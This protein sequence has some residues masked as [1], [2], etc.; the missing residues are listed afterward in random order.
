MRQT[1]RDAPP[2]QEPSD[3]ARHG[4]GE[5]GDQHHHPEEGEERADGD[6]LDPLGELRGIDLETERERAD[7]RKRDE[8]ADEGASAQRRRPD[9]RQ[10]VDCRDRRGARRTQRGNERRAD[11]DHDAD[12]HGR[13]DGA[14]QQHRGRL[15]RAEPE[16]GEA[17]RTQQE[18]CQPDPGGETQPGRDD[19]DD[20][21]L[22][23]DRAHH[24]RSAGAQRA[25][26][27]ELTRALRDED[28]EGVEDDERAD[29]E[30]H[31]READQRQA[32]V[33]NALT[34]GLG[35]LLGQLRRR[36]DLVARAERRLE[37]ACDGPR[38]GAGIGRDVDGVER[39]G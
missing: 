14:G 21:G 11:G 15:G 2:R 17:D 9:T 7:A 5:R 23:N 28:R 20:R 26:Q 30:P 27:A 10:L 37:I 25:E 36:D 19:T 18:S 39:A 32:E 8:Q 22:E 29:D 24:L 38:R 31:G 6:D 12:D 33:A 13:D 16:P 4:A 35:A 3:D 34:D 1:A